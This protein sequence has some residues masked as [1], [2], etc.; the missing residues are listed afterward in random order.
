[1]FDHL[2]GPDFNKKQ[3]LLYVL[4]DQIVDSTLAYCIFKSCWRVV[5]IAFLLQTTLK[6][7]TFISSQKA[8]YGSRPK[9]AKIPFRK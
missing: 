4:H 9:N 6:T 2:R 1:M 5:S 8:A 7:V 3:Q